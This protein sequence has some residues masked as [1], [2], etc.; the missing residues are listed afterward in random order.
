MRTPRELALEALSDP[1]VARRTGRG[2]HVLDDAEERILFEDLKTCGLKVRRLRELLAFLR[3][4]W[5]DLADDDPSWLRTTEEE[6]VVGLVRD[7]LAFTGGM[8]EEEL[9]PLA[10]KALRD[11]PAVVRRHARTHVLVDDYGTL[12]RAAQA[13]T[14]LIAAS[15]IAVA[16]DDAAL[17]S[18]CE[19]HPYAAWLD[20]LRRANPQTSVSILSRCYRPAAIARMLNNTRGDKTLGGLPVEAATD[21]DRDAGEALTVCMEASLADECRAVVERV[22]HAVA[23]GTQAHDILIAG[24]NGVWRANVA[25][26]LAACGISVRRLDVA[27]GCAGEDA[28]ALAT[29]IAHDPEDSLAWRSWCGLGDHLARSAAV[30][31]LRRRA[32]AGTRLA[33]ALRLLEQGALGSFREDDPLRTSLVKRYREGLL[34]VQQVDVASSPAQE[35]YAEATEAVLVGS[36]LDAFGREASLVVFGGFVNGFIPSRAFCDPGALV[37]RARARAR[38]SDLQALHLCAA[39]ARQKLVFTG[40]TSCGLETAE[41]LGLHIVR[42]RLVDGMRIC[43]I[44]PSELLDIVQA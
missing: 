1:D 35:S 16:A 30:A 28:Q 10:F 22:R 37:G 38:R 3:R 42:I 4:G 40:F 31:E 34:A 14:N 21:D 20:D 6:L 25:K 8:L 15:S 26:A 32:P 23:E 24:T 12:G 17:P 36:P 29:R 7:A 27:R 33:E 5:S 9:I 2:T 43:T 13:L 19:P 39:S 44:E 41:R 18:P 11:D